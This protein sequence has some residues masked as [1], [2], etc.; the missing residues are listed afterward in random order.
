VP[1]TAYT[2]NH[3][4]IT[5]GLYEPE[6]GRL[7]VLAADQTV[8]GDGVTVGTVALEPKPS[9]LP[10]PLQANFGNE[11]ELVGYEMGPRALRSGETFTVTLYWRPQGDTQWD[12]SVFAQ[13]IDPSWQVWG[14]QD[15]AG[16]DWSAGSVVQDVRTITLL[17]DTPPG[18]YPVQV[19]LYHSETGRLPVLAS[20]GHHIDERVLV[21]PIRVLD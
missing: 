18:S 12:Y 7:P 8:L 19:G 14:S 3:G 4:T 15:G 11:I 20:D 17:P 16:P 13:V 2:P 1:E 21:G 6:L 5:V 10:N 9:P